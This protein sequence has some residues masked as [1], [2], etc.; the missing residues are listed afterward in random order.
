MATNKSKYLCCE[1]GVL[2][3]WGI[4]GRDGAAHAGE[5]ICGRHR[6]HT[7]T[8]WSGAISAGWKCSLTLRSPRQPK[9][10]FDFTVGRI[11]HRSHCHI[12]GSAENVL[13]WILG[14]PNRKFGLVSVKDFRSLC[15][16]MICSGKRGEGSAFGNT[17]AAGKHKLG[18][19]ITPG[20]FV[21]TIS[22]GEGQL[23]FFCS[24]IR[25]AR[26]SG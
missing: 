1:W 2:W 3:C 9:R 26:R 21:H 14:N 4:L 10:S 22:P 7:G 15:C 25:Y 13:E 18:Q 16:C 23:R 17:R 5:W 24:W 6:P 11:W 8:G 20:D 19:T 12:P